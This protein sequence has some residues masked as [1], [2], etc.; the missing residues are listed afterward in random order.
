M[1][2]GSCGDS[3]PPLFYCLFFH[4]ALVKVSVFSTNGLYYRPLL[5]QSILRK[6]LK[7]HVET[8][9]SF[10]FSVCRSLLREKLLAFLLFNGVELISGI[11]GGLGG[12]KYDRG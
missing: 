8:V 2:C 10:I 4:A 5:H 3:E 6:S 7:L 11:A 12:N 1:C 9:V